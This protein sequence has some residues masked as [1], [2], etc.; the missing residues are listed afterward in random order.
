MK[1]FKTADIII[2]TLLITGLTVWVIITNN[3]SWNL[4]K[5][6]CI[7]GAWQSLSM[8]V[9]ECMHWFTGPWKTRRIYHII[10]LILLVTM[11][12]GSVWILAF[13][14]APMALFYTGM[15][16]YELKVKTKRPLSVL[17]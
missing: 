13:S 6:Y 15:C 8:I 17:K 11:P 9:H 2:S 14:A 1:K 10:S 3:E 7:V 12:A 4:V 16:I 5:S